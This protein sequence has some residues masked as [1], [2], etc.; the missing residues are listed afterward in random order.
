MKKFLMTFIILLLTACHCGDTIMYFGE[1][2]NKYNTGVFL[3]VQ[4]E[5][6]KSY[7][8]YLKKNA[9]FSDIYNP[10]LLLE[11][12][13]KKEY[14]IYKDQNKRELIAS[15]SSIDFIKV[16]NKLGFSQKGIFKLND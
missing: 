16:G 9:I 5:N 2:K 12:K 13:D 7:T 1:L 8:L 6:E 3:E 4:K 10:I 15:F 14:F 11:Q